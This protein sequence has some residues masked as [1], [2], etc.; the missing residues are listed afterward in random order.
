M[1]KLEI[2]KYGD[3]RLRYKTKDVMK[4]SKKIKQL[5]FDMLETMYNS[6]GVGLAAPQV[7]DF[8]RIFV[9]D[10]SDP[11]APPN[12]MVFINPKI[13]KKSG[14]LNSYEGCLSFPQAYTY[15][16][17]YSKITMR[18]QDLDGRYFTLE[19]DAK[20][21][22]L[23]VKALQHEFDHLNGILFVDHAR[24]IEETN[25]ILEEN[26]LNPIEDENF[27]AEEELENEVSKLPPTEE[28]LTREKLIKEEK[29]KNVLS[30]EGN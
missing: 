26:N 29:A 25:K 6:N 12:P 1:S 30:D 7:G 8:N 9:I 23:L 27:L 22:E 5:V 28:E 19:A 11:E 18:A 21:N 16:R 14:A 20:D 13:I 4:F 17:R 10:V 2:V 3:K 15:V 24:N